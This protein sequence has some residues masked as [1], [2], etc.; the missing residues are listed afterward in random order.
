MAI[1]KRRT[2]GWVITLSVIVLVLNITMMVVWIVMTSGSREWSILAIGTVA[3]TLMMAATTVYVILSI[4]EM[5]VSQQQADFISSVTHELKTPLATLRLYLETLQMRDLPA[6]KREE[7]YRVM[8]R[9]LKRLD[10]LIS[11]LLEMRRLDDLG[12]DAERE[13]VPLHALIQQCAQRAC[14]Y[15]EKD[16]AVVHCDVPPLVL[17]APRMALEM[18]FGNLLDNALKYSGDDAQVTV[19]AHALP[20]ERVLVRITDNGCGIPRSA[21]R[22]VFRMFYRGKGDAAR[23]RPGT[24]IG[25][26]VVRTAVKMLKGRVSFRPRSDGPGTVFEVT[27]PGRAVR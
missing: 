15:H 26:Y 9:E 14:A 11:H 5:R 17:R 22:R 8:Q 27:L 7:F 25:L 4:K 12:P 21:G 23:R 6:E 1:S 13:D 16:P 20:G 18:I 24:G 3:F 19:E 2:I 10:D